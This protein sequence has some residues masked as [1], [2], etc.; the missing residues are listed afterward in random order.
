MSPEEGPR[1]RLA[2]ALG[3]PLGPR[4]AGPAGTAV[5]VLLVLVV[6]LHDLGARS[7]YTLDLP[8]FGVLAREMIRSGEW[9]VP[10]RWGQVYANKP[11]LEIWLIAAPAALWGEVT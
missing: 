6:A 8:R 10:V 4:A 3:D 1:D 9:L 2:A 7:L 5:F 11:P